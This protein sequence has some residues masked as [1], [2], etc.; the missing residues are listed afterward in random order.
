MKDDLSTYEYL[1]EMI[2]K[3][4]PGTQ[5][6]NKAMHPNDNQVRHLRN[7]KYS[8]ERYRTSAITKRN[9]EQRFGIGRLH[10]HYK[11]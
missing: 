8:M 2:R 5:Y 3:L 4:D 1:P 10:A 6:P 11:F 7:T 9:N